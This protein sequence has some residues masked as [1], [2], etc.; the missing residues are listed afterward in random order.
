MYLKSE[1]LQVWP[2]AKTFIRHSFKNNFIIIILQIGL[3]VKYGK[4]DKTRALSRFYF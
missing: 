3:V 2:D 4:R 1:F